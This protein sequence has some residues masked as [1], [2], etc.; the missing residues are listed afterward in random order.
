MM[1]KKEWSAK[2]TEKW[3]NTLNLLKSVWGQPKLRKK[4]NLYLTKEN[5]LLHEVMKMMITVNKNSQVLQE[6]K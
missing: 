5:K 2:C 6:Y 4:S 3:N 1:I